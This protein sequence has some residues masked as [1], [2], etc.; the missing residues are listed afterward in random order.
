V[1]EF[2]FYNERNRIN[3]NPK[4]MTYTEQDLLDRGFVEYQ[5][6]SGDITIQ[7][8]GTSLSLIEVNINGNY[9]T[10]NIQSLSELDTVIKVFG[11]NK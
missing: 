11:L 2:L 7:A 9:T 4:Q 3:P 5:L 1:A 8:S 6:N 10:L